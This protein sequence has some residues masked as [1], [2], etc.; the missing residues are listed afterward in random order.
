[1][2]FTWQSRHPGRWPGLSKWLELRPAKR[3]QN[4]QGPR[5]RRCAAARRPP[6]TIF[7]P[8][9]ISSGQTQQPWHLVD[10]N[11][12]A[13]VPDAG[14]KARRFALPRPTAW[15]PMTREKRKG[16]WPYGFHLAVTPPRPLAWAKQMAGASPRKTNAKRAGASARFHQDRPATIRIAPLPVGYELLSSLSIACIVAVT[17][18]L[19]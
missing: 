6:A 13:P 15:D 3:M 19:L 11:A 18:G 2:E 9:G 1:M 5:L 17:S 8:F 16:R 14:P 4:G 7:H 10:R 12:G